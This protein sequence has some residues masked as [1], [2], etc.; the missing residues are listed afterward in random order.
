MKNCVESF[1]GLDSLNAFL[2]KFNF[3]MDSI[4]SFN[5]IKKI[6]KADGNFYV[7]YI[8]EGDKVE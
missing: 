7:W 5:P 8:A 6:F 3:E 2:N 1:G 4:P